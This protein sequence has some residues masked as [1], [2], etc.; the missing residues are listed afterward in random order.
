[1][2][3]YKKIILKKGKE[4]SL[5][6]RHPWIFSGAIYSADNELQEGDVVNVFVY[7]DSEERLV[8]TTQKSLVEV[9]HFAFL[10][11]KWINEHGA[12]LDWGL[13]KD[14]F[15]PFK[16]QKQ[17]IKDFGNDRMDHQTRHEAEAARI[18]AQYKID[19]R[20]FVGDDFS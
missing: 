6:R 10:E 12:F 13:M 9:N 11:V 15:C 17:K 2:S 3:D 1:M 20:R 7:L 8:A 14:L 19:L 5:L 16:E 18:P 4:D